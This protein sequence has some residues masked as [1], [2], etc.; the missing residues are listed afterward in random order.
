MTAHRS[1]QTRVPSSQHRNKGS[2]AFVP[3][4]FSWHRHSTSY[5]FLAIPKMVPERVWVLEVQS[6]PGSAG[7]RL[8]SSPA[9]LKIR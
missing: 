1:K 4:P 2:G 3:P 5:G 9:T 8:W 7:A 6:S